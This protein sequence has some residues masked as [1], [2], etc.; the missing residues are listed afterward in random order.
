MWTFTNLPAG[1]IADMRGTVNG[2]FIQTGYYTFS[3][4]V[5]DSSGITTD[6]YITINAQPYS[7]LTSNQSTLVEV[8]NRNTAMQYDLVKI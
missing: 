7:A 1:L 8:P 2:S 4:T 3:A 5:A 6:S